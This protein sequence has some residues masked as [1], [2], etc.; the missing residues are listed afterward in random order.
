MEE[1]V[2]KIMV[3]LRSLQRELI[4]KQ[5]ELDKVKEECRVKVE[6]LEKEVKSLAA[7]VESYRK[8]H[9]P[10]LTIA[11]VND[12][13]SGKRYVRASIRYYVEGSNRQ[14]TTSIHLGK[15]SDFPFGLNDDN[16]LALAQKKAIELLIRKKDAKNAELGE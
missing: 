1:S 2:N 3:M 8:Q 15:L 10:N 11:E 9:I 16:L 12:K 7:K 14:K 5:S 4:D 6:P 13:T